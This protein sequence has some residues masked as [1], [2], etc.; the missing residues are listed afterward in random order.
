[1]TAWFSKMDGHHNETEERKREWMGR[2]KK[3][4]KSKRA[5]K[6]TLGKWGVH[7]NS[8]PVISLSDRI[9]YMANILYS[10]RRLLYYLPRLRLIL[11]VPP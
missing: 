11:S 5:T 4:G 8:G 3:R 7:H 9:E 2:E 1:M 10:T 6:V